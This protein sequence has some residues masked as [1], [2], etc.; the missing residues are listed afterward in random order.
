MKTV[1]IRLLDKYLG[2]PLCFFLTLCRRIAETFR[3]RVPK[4]SPQKILFVKLIE[5]GSTVL[6]YSAIKK[7]EGK[8]GR[9]N[10]YFLVFRENKPIL[11]ILNLVS[12]DNI[13]EIN[14]KNPI[15]FIITYLRALLKARRLKLDA[16]LDMESFSRGTAVLSYLTGAA[17]RIGYHPFGASCY[18]GDLYTHRMAHNPYLH[19][20]TAFL[21]LVE[22]L[23]HAPPPKGPMAFVIPR[24]DYGIPRFNASSH[25][26]RNI[27]RVIKERK[28]SEPGKPII[29]LNPQPGD[30]IPERRW[31]P[32]K[33][34]SLGN[35]I[36]RGYPQATI[37]VTGTNKSAE[38]EELSKEIKGAVSLAGMT[39]LK[40]LLALYIVSDLLITSD[41]GAAHFASITPIRALVFFGP[42][43][44]FLYGTIPAGHEVIKADYCCSPCIRVYNQRKAFCA[45]ALCLRNIGVERVFER[46]KSIIP[47]KEKS[48]SFDGP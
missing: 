45:E 40:K 26:K 15:T 13:I 11:E 35:M 8:V 33:Y 46:V 1:T 44:P 34:V 43:T 20:R 7:A 27:I 32:D 24:D 42:E 5:Q 31:P 19:T 12:P 30:L 48:S 21:T 2:I 6:A 16:L 41:S 36:A 39:D 37:V 10:I 29:I 14:P 28:G 18:M 17:M 38:L 4:G 25:E 9:E 23:D 47:P 3:K 22:A